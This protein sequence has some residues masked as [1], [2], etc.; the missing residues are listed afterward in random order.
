MS[1]VTIFNHIRLVRDK[2]YYFFLNYDLQNAALFIQL[3]M[4]IGQDSK[5][6][7]PILLTSIF[8]NLAL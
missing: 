3:N 7:F 8:T 5:V 6:W 1:K 2:F 4:E